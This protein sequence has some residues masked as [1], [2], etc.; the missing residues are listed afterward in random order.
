MTKEELEKKINDFGYRRQK[1]T[2][3][4]RDEARPLIP[5]LLDSGRMN[6]AKSLQELFFEYDALE[7]EFKE[8]A[9]A[10]PMEAFLIIEKML[11]KK[12]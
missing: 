5:V 11:T 7:Q 8:L 9:E 4:I 2:D 6:S 10:Y 12:K 1:L 3:R